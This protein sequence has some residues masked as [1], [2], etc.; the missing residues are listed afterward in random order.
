MAT[1]IPIGT[2]AY[3]TS[4]VDGQGTSAASYY[5][6]AE[7]HDINYLLLRQTINQMIDE[8]SAVSGPN[9]I[10]ALDLVLW[11]DDVN[12]IAGGEQNYGVVGAASYEVSIE[13]GSATLKCRKG[14][15]F[16]SGQRASLVSD[17]TGIAYVGGATT[18][19]VA[20]DANGAVFISN[21]ADDK[22]LDIAS[23]AWNGSIF[24]GSVT[25][26]ADVFFDGDSWAE[27]RDRAVTPNSPT[28]GAYTFRR[29]AERIRA[30]ELFLAG[31]DT[32]AEGEPIAGPL[33]FLPGSVG[34]PSLVFGDGGS[35][36]DTSSGWY[37]PSAERW[38]FSSG[39]VLQQTF[40]PSGIIS[41]YLGTATDPAF[42]SSAAG[43]YFPASDE[44][45]IGAAGELAMRWK[46][47]TDR[48]QAL[49]ADGLVGFPSLA[50]DQDEDSGWYSPAAAEWALSLGGVKRFHFAADYFRVPDGVVGTPSIAF[51]SDPDTGFFLDA[52]GE[53]AVALGG[54]HRFH[55]A[56][57]QMH[58]PDGIV[59]LPTYAFENDNDTGMY[60][61]GVGRLGFVTAGA[62]GGEFDAVGNLDLPL[63]FGAIV[64]RVSGQPGI[65]S[66]TPTS[67]NWD[68]EDEDRGGWIA[69]TSTDLTCPTDGDGLYLVTLEV[70][71][72]SNAS[73][74]GY[75]DVWLEVGGTVYG[76][77]RYDQ[78]NA[79]PHY[80]T[81]DA[82]IRLAATDVLLG[83]V[84]HTQGAGQTLAAARLVVQKLA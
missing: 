32:G 73:P 72:P 79:W 19:Y 14:Q 70:E 36:I 30:L 10:A 45:A 44:A 35:T 66:A 18:C 82:I 13:G 81:T 41:A 65:V 25:H 47:D 2:A 84:E 68:T 11:D 28:F 49:I 59:S 12:P 64:R 56:L 54:V 63:N 7:D 33:V 58:G 8:I 40:G 20:I 22:S 21:V 27:V 37:R 80:Q 55:F 42:R 17:Q 69:V 48:P 46:S 3:L 15:A 9:A 16:V 43:L 57:N 60:S 78:W 77:D 74:V 71:W 67:I 26:L 31:Q 75:R 39:G 53:I 1:K 29:G 24:T 76:H 5:T 4:F 38:A 51:E 52:V 23:V 83:R 6:Y 34:A 61:P 62:K 50:L